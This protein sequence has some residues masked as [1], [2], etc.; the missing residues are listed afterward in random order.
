MAPPENTSDEF[1]PLITG[2]KNGTATSTG[3]GT[4]SNNNDD[5]ERNSTPSQTLRK[6][7]TS[8]PSDLRNSIQSLRDLVNEHTGA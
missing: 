7:I 6:I 8:A 2:F 4:S 3:Y 1:N 5:D